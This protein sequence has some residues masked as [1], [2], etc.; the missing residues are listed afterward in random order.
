M[1]AIQKH[2]TVARALAWFT[3]IYNLAEGIISTFYGFEEETLSLFGFGVDSF[4][5]MISSIGI[6]VM[7]FRIEKNPNSP[8][9]TFEKKAL[10]LTGYCLYALAIIL[11]LTAAVSIYEAHI[12]QDTLPGIIISCVSIGIMYVLIKEKIKVGKALDSA[13]I[14]ADANCARVCMYMSMVLLGSSLL[15]YFIQIPYIDAIG[16]IGIAYFSYSE[17]KESLQKAAGTHD[18]SCHD[19]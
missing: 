10:Q 13:A 1:E 7:I 4:I 5:E 18:C 2:Y 15:A 19:H 11:V 17:G 6:L 16:A 8:N 14:V 3:I 12:P 9:S